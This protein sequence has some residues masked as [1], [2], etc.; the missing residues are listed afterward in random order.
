MEDILKGFVSYGLGGCLAA[1]S[2]WMLWHMVTVGIPR[3]QSEF[4]KEI[5]DARDEFL[6]K[7][8]RQEN[9]FL[10]SLDQ[11]R[12]AGKALVQEIIHEVSQWREAMYSGPKG[13]PK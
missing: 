10:D 4:R 12:A 7:L 13:G 6:K 9:R 8:E 2:A 3:M 1:C 5:R 11:Q